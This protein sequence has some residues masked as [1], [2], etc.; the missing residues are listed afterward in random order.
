MPLRVESALV[1]ESLLPG[2]GGGLR[3]QDQLVLDLGRIG[4]VTYV[5]SS[6]QYH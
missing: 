3:L 2:P 1:R 5:R 6:F 4:S